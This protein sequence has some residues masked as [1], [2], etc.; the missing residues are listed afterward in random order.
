MEP[1]GSFLEMYEE[2]RERRHSNK[3]SAPLVAVT[4]IIFPV[5]ET[6]HKTLAARSRKGIFQ[7][8]VLEVSVL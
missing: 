1:C 3:G 2:R 6:K 4:F 5:V 8:M 7:L